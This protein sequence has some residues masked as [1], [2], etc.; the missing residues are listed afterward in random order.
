MK[1]FNKQN[2][3]PFNYLQL[4]KNDGRVKLTKAYDQQNSLDLQISI[5]DDFEDCVEKWPDYLKPNVSEK[6]LRIIVS[7][8]DY[9]KRTVWNNNK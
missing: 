6:V 2:K 1:Y 7:Y 5:H 9:I 3:S 4:Y 8:T